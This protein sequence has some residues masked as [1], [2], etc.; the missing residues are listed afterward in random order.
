MLETALNEEMT[1][2]LGHEKNQAEPG[3]E[4]TNV[5]NGSRGKTVISDAAGEV[6][7]DVPR[8]REGTFEPQIVK[9]RQRR[10]TDVDEI[11]LSL[12]AKGCRPGRSPRISRRST[13]RRCRKR[14][15]PGS[16]TKWWR[17]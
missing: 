7:I 11:V 3:R 8:D 5:R 1:E 17:R 6:R 13:G 16:P 2:H 15:F 14:R 4:S 10:L 9:K 12:Y